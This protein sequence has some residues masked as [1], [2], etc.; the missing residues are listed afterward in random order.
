MPVA[1][2]GPKLIEFAAA[3]RQLQ[4][5]EGWPAQAHS[6]EGFFGLVAGRV[7]GSAK[8]FFPLAGCSGSGPAG[9]ETLV[10]ETLGSW[11]RQ[12]RIDLCLSSALGRA[13][14]RTD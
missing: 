7:C 14:P 12:N 9:E 13:L 5:D 2:S 4:D 11:F 8:K 10:P 6:K 3:L 1:I